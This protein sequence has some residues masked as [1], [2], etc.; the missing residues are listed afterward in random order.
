MKSK[1]CGEQNTML[2]NPFENLERLRSECSLMDKAAKVAYLRGKLQQLNNMAYQMT[3]YI[4][5]KGYTTESKKQQALWLIDAINTVQ[6]EGQKASRELVNEGS[7]EMVKRM[8]KM[9]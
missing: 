6:N 1:Q 7:M 3:L 2:N 5:S 4:R 8:M 9:Y